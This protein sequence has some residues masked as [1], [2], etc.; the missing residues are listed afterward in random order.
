VSRALQPDFRPRFHHGIGNPNLDRS[1]LTD[2]K[3]RHLKPQAKMYKVADRDGVYV[4]VTP[5]G[6]ISFRY[7]YALSGRQET[8][9]YSSV[10]RFSFPTPCHGGLDAKVTCY[11][12]WGERRCYRSNPLATS[13]AL[14]HNRSSMP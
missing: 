9:I 10:N 4:A 13:G 12:R 11:S 6:G 5:A 2:T 1:M 3:L 7:N 8:M 14:G